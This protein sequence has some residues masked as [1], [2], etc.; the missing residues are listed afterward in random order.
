M[1]PGMKSKIVKRMLMNNLFEHPVLIPKAMGG[2]KL[3]IAK[4]L[5]NYL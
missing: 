4:S 5:A 1:A 3:L 2:K